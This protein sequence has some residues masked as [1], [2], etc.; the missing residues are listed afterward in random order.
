[1][2]GELARKSSAVI[3]NTRPHVRV[4]KGNTVLV[5]RNRT[6]VA[7][8]VARLHAAGLIER[9]YRLGRTPADE[10]IA[11]TA[12]R[13]PRS[14][15]RR[16]G[17]RLSLAA[18]ATVAF[19]AGLAWAV[20]ALVAAVAAALPIVAGLLGVLVLLGALAAISSG[21]SVIEVVQKVRIR[22]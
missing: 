11:W 15:L 9:D 7:Q 17:L 10:W 16:N 6:V 3:V 20:R 14:W 18:S 1:M 8:E 21:G 5:H 4:V 2:Y 12:A 19:L 13:A 22:R